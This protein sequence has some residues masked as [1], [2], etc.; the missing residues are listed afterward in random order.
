MNMINLQTRILLRLIMPI[1]II[2][3]ALCLFAVWIGSQTPAHVVYAHTSDDALVWVDTQRNIYLH[4]DFPVQ[5]D[6]LTFSDDGRQVVMITELINQTQF[7]NWNIETGDWGIIPTPSGRCVGFYAYWLH[8]NQAIAIGCGSDTLA[9]LYRFDV[10]QN[11]LDVIYQLAYQLT[12]T[13]YMAW[14]PNGDY[15]A[16]TRGNSMD[17]IELATGD[18]QTISPS[19]DVAYRFAMWHPNHRS[20]FAL[21]G[22]VIQRYDLDTDTWTAIASD[23][24][25]FQSIQLSPDGEW[26]AFINEAGRAYTIHIETGATTRLQTYDFIVEDVVWLN[27]SP[28]SEWI[29][30][31]IPI[32]SEDDEL[33]VIRPDASELI[34]FGAGVMSQ[35]PVWSPDGDRIAYVAQRGNIPQLFI[36][37]VGSEE[38]FIISQARNP[39]WSLD[40]TAII[41]EYFVGRV[42]RASQLG[43][44]N[45]QT[46]AYFFTRP[47]VRVE[48][49]GFVR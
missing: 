20:L 15:V 2:T 45:I 3:G 4:Y 43:Y 5:T 10:T 40:S 26:L 8:Q 27:W 9:R 30:L 18:S 28:T 29:M 34:V 49:V 21:V 14:S 39:R 22:E 19:T 13:Y 25:G 42:T 31:S 44:Y 46:G 12:Q 32:R 23:S 36:W 6:R 33:Y 7:T 47:S 38:Q 48:A 41:F 37:E 1:L 17:L 11:R 24:V 35:V 16:I